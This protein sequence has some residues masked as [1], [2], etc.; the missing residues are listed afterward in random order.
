MISL[1]FM[2]NLILCYRFRLHDLIKQ[3]FR[4]FRVERVEAL[5]KP[6]A[7]RSE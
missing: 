7:H 2:D 1:M 4:L 5:G 3:R 6:P